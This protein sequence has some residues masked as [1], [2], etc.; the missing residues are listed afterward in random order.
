MGCGRPWYLCRSRPHRSDCADDDTLITRFAA[1][2]C[3]QG[4]HHMRATH[5]QYIVCLRL[6]TFSLAPAFTLPTIRLPTY[7]T[8]SSPVVYHLHR[9]S[10][11]RLL[12]QITPLCSTPSAL[13]QPSSYWLVQ[14]D[15]RTSSFSLNEKVRAIVARLIRA[16]SGRSSLIAQLTALFAPPASQTSP[17]IAL[18][19]SASYPIRYTTSRPVSP[20][21][22]PC[23][24]DIHSL[25]S[26]V[27]ILCHAHHSSTRQSPFPCRAFHSSAIRGQ[28][29]ERSGE[30]RTSTCHYGQEQTTTDFRRTIGTQADARSD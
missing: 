12:L 11:V 22:A 30:G 18:P 24:V 20:F 28:T 29:C 23:V 19:E 13:T 25:T 14:H 16:S 21:S 5:A 8:C 2:A 15:Y 10:L 1:R 3:A 7:P 4:T 27:F 17:L 26:T 6:S 9:S